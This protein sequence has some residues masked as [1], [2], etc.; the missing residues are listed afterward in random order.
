MDTGGWAR[1]KA[2]R[3]GRGH[4]IMG[5]QISSSQHL[6]SSRHGAG[7]QRNRLR[8]ASAHPVAASSPRLS[9]GQGVS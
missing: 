6:Q 2:E 4:L 3:Q 1:E 9:M 7:D 5:S 8:Q